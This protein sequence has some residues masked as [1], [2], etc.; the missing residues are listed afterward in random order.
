MRC[1]FVSSEQEVRKGGNGNVLAATWIGENMT[2]I[3][4]A[5]LFDKRSSS[6]AELGRQ[7]LSVTFGREEALLSLSVFTTATVMTAIDNLQNSTC[8]TAEIRS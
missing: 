4:I 7:R 6:S 3:S 5:H 1:Q 2:K 8:P